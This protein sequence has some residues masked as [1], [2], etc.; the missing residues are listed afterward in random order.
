MRGSGVMRGRSL[1]R[2]IDRPL[3][4]PRRRVTRLSPVTCQ[5][6]FVH[7]ECE[8]S[9]SLPRFSGRG[10]PEDGGAGG[11]PGRGEGG[12]V[13]RARVRVGQRGRA[14]SYLGVETYRDPSE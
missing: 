3:A 13:A 5:R 10:S 6:G 14:Y 2:D 8:S 12:R 9:S 7:F 11:S 1:V 4:R